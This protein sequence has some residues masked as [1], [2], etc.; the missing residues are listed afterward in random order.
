MIEYLFSI[1]FGINTAQGHY[2]QKQNYNPKKH[3]IIQHTDK[4]EKKLTRK[5]VNWNCRNYMNMWSFIH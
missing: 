4:S 1:K 2:I 3:G 5:E